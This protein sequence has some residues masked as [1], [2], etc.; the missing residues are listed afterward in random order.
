ML[1][2]YALQAALRERYG[3]DQILAAGEFAA[4]PEGFEMGG[5]GVRQSYERLLLFIWDHGK[6]VE[7]GGVVFRD[8]SEVR[9]PGST[10]P[11]LAIVQCSCGLPF[12]GLWEAVRWSC[13]ML[14]V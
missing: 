14:E 8:G 4:R 9:L 12:A 13:A 11:T 3:H 2:G 10:G 5:V 6:L 1:P 7:R